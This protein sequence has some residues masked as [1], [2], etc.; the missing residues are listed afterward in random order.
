MLNDIIGY[1]GGIFTTISFLPQVIKSYRTKSANDLS[2]GMIFAT[3]IGTA[4]WIIYGFLINS[5]PIIIMNVIFEII[6]LFQLFFKI[7]Y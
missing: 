2:S 7:K 5:V 3:L 1:L 4:F 6:V